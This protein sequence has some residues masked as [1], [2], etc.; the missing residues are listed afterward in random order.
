MIIFLLIIAATFAMA[1]PRSKAGY[2]FLLAIIHLA[3]AGNLDNPD[4]YYYAENFDGIRTGGQDDSFELGYQSLARIASQLGLEY[5]AFHFVLSGAA[6]LLICK[7]VMDLTD[8]PALGL[9]AYLFFPFFW[10][11]TQV[12][13]F[14]AMAI[15]IYGMKYLLVEERKSNLKYAVTILIA[16]TFHVTSVFYLLFLAARTQNKVL[17]WSALGVAAAIYT[18]VFSALVASPLLAFVAEKIDVYTTTETSLVTK[19]AVLAFY[20]ASLAML[21]WTARRMTVAD[22]GA[23]VQPLAKHSESRTKHVPPRLPWMPYLRISPTV[24]LN[25]NL[26][27][28]LSILLTLDNLDFIRLYRN[29]F[30]VNCIFVI[31]G[32]YRSRRKNRALMS[33]CFIAYLVTVFTGFVYITSTSN[34]IESTLL[35]NVVS[36]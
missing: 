1:S 21:W 7:A 32:I 2:F 12:R 24:L 19:V 23:V 18:L 14:Y 30:L 34:I 29:L 15:V 25:V 20:A 5:G 16:S 36:G 8:R 17:L 11:V 35:N 33:L 3:I 31:N 26:V 10:D 28:G 13:N 6:L 4:R 27:A 22:A 9:L